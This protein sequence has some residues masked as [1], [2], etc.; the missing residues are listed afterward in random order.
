MA[1][2]Q[3]KYRISPHR[4]KNWD[5]GSP[6][7]YFVTICTKNQICYFGDIVTSTN[8]NIHIDPDVKSQNFATI[9]RENENIEPHL[10]PSIIGKIAQQYWEEIPN[11]FPFVELDE[12]KIMPN[13]MHGILLIDNPE[14]S[15]WEHNKF[16]P[17]SKNLGSIIRGYKAGVKGY[18]TTNNIE[19]CWQAKYYDRIIR[20]EHDLD[21]VREYIRNNPMNWK[22]DKHNKNGLMR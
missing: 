18:A 22:K 3:N 19:F 11:H 2:F 1:K 20:T 10:N 5:Y 16:G 15:G 21:V 13:H 12:F 6:G 4:L 14:H 9:H 7:M 8:E 17:Q